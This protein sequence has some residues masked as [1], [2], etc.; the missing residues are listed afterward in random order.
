VI[1]KKQSFWKRSAI[2]LKANSSK[3]FRAILAPVTDLG[4]FQLPAR[5]SRTRVSALSQ[6]PLA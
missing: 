2:G 3:G 5:K 6:L 4:R 1:W